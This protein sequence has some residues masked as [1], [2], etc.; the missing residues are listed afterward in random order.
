MGRVLETT[1]RIDIDTVLACQMRARSTED[2][3]KAL[4][5]K[6]DRSDLDPHQIQQA[7]LDFW[8]ARTKDELI[9]RGATDT[10]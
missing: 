7:K 4:W 6:L 8:E 1:G 3:R 2:L 10:I 5:D 9:A